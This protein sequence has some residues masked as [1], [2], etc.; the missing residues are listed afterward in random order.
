MSVTGWKNITWPV[1]KSI[2]IEKKHNY[3]KF[4]R[5]TFIFYDLFISDTN[6]TWTCFLSFIVSPNSLQS[7]W[8]HGLL[9]F[10]KSN[11]TRVRTPNT[12]R[13]FFIYYTPCSGE[14]YKQSILYDNIEQLDDVTCHFQQYFKLYHGCQFYYMFVVGPIFRVGLS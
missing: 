5:I 2:K 1:T 14:E 4:I 13:I 12:E 8:C 9:L 11:T 10:N 3:Y 6:L 7:N